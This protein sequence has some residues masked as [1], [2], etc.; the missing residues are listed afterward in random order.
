MNATRSTA[1]CIAWTG[2]KKRYQEAAADV[3]DENGRPQPAWA[4]ITTRCG[5]DLCIH[6]DHLLG[7]APVRLAYPALVCVYCGRSG[8]TKDHLLPRHWSGDAKR[9]FVVTV[10]ACGTCN[11]L[12]SDTLTWSITERRAICHARMRK[13]FHP[14]LRTIDRTPAELAEFGPTLRAHI[15]DGMARK[16]EVERMLAWP[17]DPDYDLRALQ[18]SGIENGYISG[19][20]EDQDERFW[21]H[22]RDAA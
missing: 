22:V 16:A 13:R 8:Y 12:L 14:V 4:W 11:S 21:Q 5:D 17:E 18:K 10:P 19:L 3:L 9:H 15:E 20:L 6:P 7:H 1:A 2:P